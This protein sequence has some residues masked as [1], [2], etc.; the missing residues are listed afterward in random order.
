MNTEGMIF[1]ARN[2]LNREER[3]MKIEAWNETFHNYVEIM[4]ECWYRADDPETLTKSGSKFH[5]IFTQVAKF[6]LKTSIW[7]FEKSVERYGINSYAKSIKEAKELLIKHV[8]VLRS[9]G[10]T[11]E[12]VQLK[13]KNNSAVPSQELIA[14][15]QE[16]CFSRDYATRYLLAC[17]F[18][19]TKAVQMVEKAKA[20]KRSLSQSRDSNFSDSESSVCSDTVRASPV[21]PSSQ[22][23][24]E[25][26]SV[27]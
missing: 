26:Y 18:N 1:L 9:E 3:S 24:L 10:I 6:H 25:N 13:Q 19:E 8:E 7:G 21:I 14:K 23:F 11:E 16:Y 5:T 20:K 4:E 27:F 12:S 22:E 15:C 2:T 17:N